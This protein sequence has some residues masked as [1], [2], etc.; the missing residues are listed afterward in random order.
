MKKLVLLIFTIFLVACS[1]NAMDYSNEGAAVDEENIEET[2]E[3][4]S[5]ISIDGS[6]YELSYIDSFNYICNAFSNVWIYNQSSFRC[7]PF[8]ITNDGSFYYINDKLYSTTNQNCALYNSDLKISTYV[9]NDF[10][11]YRFYSTDGDFYEMDV[12]DN[13]VWFLTKSDLLPESEY[14]Y[15]LCVDEEIIY[16]EQDG[17]LSSPSY[18]YMEA[19]YYVLKNDGIIYKY[20][21]ICRYAGRDY[22]N[23]S[24]DY[25]N[26]F[27]FENITEEPYLSFEGEKI[28]YFTFDKENNS[29][30][31]TDKNIYINSITNKSDC[32][33]YADIACEYEYVT[34]EVLNS[35]LKENVLSIYCFDNSI[36]ITTSKG[37]YRYY[38]V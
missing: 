17:S 21:Y 18:D 24:G 37:I 26:I 10:D 2:E 23:N 8:L 27:S 13:G 5:T 32:D 6:S 25:N 1:N 38:T 20:S 22:Y 9:V 16:A 14:F 11:D 4:S 29:Y 12:D 30:I 34:D 15:P 36:C 7:T 31:I 3:I 28:K 35:Y 33:T 19:N